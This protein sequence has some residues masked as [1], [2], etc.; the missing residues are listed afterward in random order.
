NRHKLKHR[1]LH[2][3]TRKHFFT[4]RVIKHWHRL[5]REVVESP[6]LE[7]FKSHLD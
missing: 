5:H 2:L 4:G 1:R 7:I 3:N 6:F